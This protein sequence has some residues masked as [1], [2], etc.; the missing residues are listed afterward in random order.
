MA[1]SKQE[2]QC[3]CCGQVY[4][5]CTH[6]H[7]FDP[8]E[9]WRYLYHDEICMKINEIRRAYL[10][11]EISK[12][13]ARKQ[14]EKLVPNINIVLESNSAISETVKEI[15]DIKKENEEPAESTKDDVQMEE[16]SSNDKHQTHTKIQYRN[17]KPKDK[18]DK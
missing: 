15:F 10:G 2:R 13:D 9:L 8:T 14:M 16:N 17:S 5:F 11:K 6:C 7:D 4:K 18:S 1:N 3:I 12:E